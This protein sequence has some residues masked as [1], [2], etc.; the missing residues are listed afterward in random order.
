[1]TFRSFSVCGLERDLFA[2]FS[3]GLVA[4]VA[5]VRRDNS[6][7]LGKLAIY[8]GF[9]PSHSDPRALQLEAQI[10]GL[11]VWA[12]SLAVIPAATLDLPTPPKTDLGRG[13]NN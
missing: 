6:D 9:H 3:S 12:A 4:V 13:L 5:M 2:T 11:R 1:M 8:Q 10:K 7:M